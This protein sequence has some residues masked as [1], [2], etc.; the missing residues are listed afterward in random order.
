MLVKQKIQYN[1]CHIAESLI[2]QGTGEPISGVNLDYPV[3][4]SLARIRQLTS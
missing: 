1:S 3:G 4:L 2:L